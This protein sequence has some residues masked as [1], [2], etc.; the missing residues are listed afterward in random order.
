MRR[1]SSAVSR[2]RVLVLSSVLLLPARLDSAPDGVLLPMASTCR[3]LGLWLM[4]AQEL[5]VEALFLLARETLGRQLSVVSELLAIV[6][7]GK[8]VDVGKTVGVVRIEVAAAAA[9]DEDGDGM[10][11]VADANEE[12]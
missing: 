4:L 1:G 2:V 12:E 10:V 9:V 8:V 6:E 11:K 5:S 3:R 7:A